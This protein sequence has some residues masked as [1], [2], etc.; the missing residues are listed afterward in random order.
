MEYWPWNGFLNWYDEAT[1]R[2]LQ[3]SLHSD[4]EADFYPTLNR[5][6]YDLVHTEHEDEL[7][8]RMITFTPNLDRFEIDV[9]GSGWRESPPE[10]TW[11]LRRSA[12]NTLAIR[13]RNK[14]GH[15]GKPSSVEIMYH[16]KEPYA[17]KPKTK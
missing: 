5:V 17:P 10:F 13:V 12:L 15:T 16:Y 3:Y 8:V 11:K 7:D 2:L 4:R 6:E 1:P 9:D 14:F